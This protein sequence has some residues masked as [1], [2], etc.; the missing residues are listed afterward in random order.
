MKGNDYEAAAIL[1][2]NGR[3]KIEKIYV[4]RSMSV[5]NLLFC[6]HTLYM[7]YLPK[8]FYWFVPQCKVDKDCALCTVKAKNRKTT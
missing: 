6:L 1:K 5:H 7:T 2:I 3:K 4:G 8:C